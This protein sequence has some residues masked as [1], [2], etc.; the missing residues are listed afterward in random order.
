MNLYFAERRNFG[1][2]VLHR[3]P[4]LSSSGQTRGFHNFR[5]RANY[6]FLPAPAAISSYAAEPRSSAVSRGANPVAG[7]ATIQ[8]R[9]VRVPHAGGVRIA[10]RLRNARWRRA[11][12]AWT[13]LCSSAD[14]SSQ[15]MPSSQ[16]WTTSC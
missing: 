6:G 2:R 8:P 5:L 16:Q 1:N 12:M 7:Q 4:H 14:I 3:G 13:V 9:Q 10:F 11:W 15:D